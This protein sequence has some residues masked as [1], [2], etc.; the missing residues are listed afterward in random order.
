MKTLENKV[1]INLQYQEEN[2]VI[3][4][5]PA[6]RE[7]SREEIVINLL[8]KIDVKV[9]ASDL[10]LERKDNPPLILKLVNHKHAK[11]SIKKR[12]RLKNIDKSFISD[13]FNGKIFIN[14]NLTPYFAKLS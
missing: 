2:I 3:D 5:L 8:N 7:D 1:D 10:L 9:S 4:G 14:E 11:L 6:L 13:N 12:S